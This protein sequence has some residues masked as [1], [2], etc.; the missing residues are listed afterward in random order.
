LQA[1][2]YAFGLNHLVKCLVGEPIM[3][4]FFEGPVARPR[5]EPDQAR[6]LEMLATL[7]ITALAVATLYVGREIFIPIAIAIPVS[8][9][10]SPP[11]LLLRRWGLVESPPS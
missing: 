1:N 2:N 5:P 8:F 11:V 4:R 6:T 7:L 10:L 3:S 9:V